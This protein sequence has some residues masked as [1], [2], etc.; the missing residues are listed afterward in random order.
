MRYFTP[1]WAWVSPAF[2]AEMLGI[3]KV[4]WQSGDLLWHNSLGLPRLGAYWL[5]LSLTELVGRAGSKL[6]ILKAPV[7]K[8]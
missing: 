3:A 7:R 5:S 1:T 4:M 6:V 2:S 8:F